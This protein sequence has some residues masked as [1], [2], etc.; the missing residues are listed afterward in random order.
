MKKCSKCDKLKPLGEYGKHS[1][2]RQC[3]KV[4]NRNRKQINRAEI[5][6]S[7]NNWAKSNPIAR[8]RGQ[9]KSKYGL[10]P[11]DYDAM[12]SKQLGLCAI[13]KNAET[14]PTRSNDKPRCLSIDHCH[15]TGKVRGFLCAC[16]NHA[17]GLIKENFDIALNMAKYIQEH[18]NVT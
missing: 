4:Y 6:E 9:S 7:K 8:H 2:C 17:L 3:N 5:N 10:A 12:L 1:Y 15:D 16:C 13:C 14:V 18:R 11:E